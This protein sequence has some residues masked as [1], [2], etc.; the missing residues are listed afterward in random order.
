MAFESLKMSCVDTGICDERIESFTSSISEVYSTSSTSTACPNESATTTTSKWS[1]CVIA[2]D[3]EPIA[4]SVCHDSRELAL[5]TY[6]TF[7]T[8]NPTTAFPTKTPTTSLLPL[9]DYKFKAADFPS[10]RINFDLDKVII[11]RAA[12]DI[13]MAKGLISTEKVKNLAM[14][15]NLHGTTAIEG[16]DLIRLLKDFPNLV[17]LRFVFGTGWTTRHG[18][19]EALGKKVALPLQEKARGQPVND[20]SR[21]Q[22]VFSS[23]ETIKRTFWNFMSNFVA[24][25]QWTGLVF[26]TAFQAAWTTE[27]QTFEA[28]MRGLKIRRLVADYSLKIMDKDQLPLHL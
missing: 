12:R 24:P 9:P 7:L 16:P 25:H 13:P 4:L 26:D 14:D 8:K 1:P 17:N 15:L 22:Y 28:H 19:T 6:E 10:M 27:A 2:G 20:I 18:M 11:S 5:K 23:R 21:L 3:R